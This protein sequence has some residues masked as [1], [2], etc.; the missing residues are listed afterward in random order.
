[1]STP[2]LLPQSLVAAVEATHVPPLPQVLLRLLEAVEDDNVS[3]A[4]LAEL[5]SRDPVLT[6]RVLTAANSAAFRRGMAI[7]RIQDCVKVLGTRLVRA[8]ATCLAVQHTFDPMSRKLRANL[9]EFWRHSMMVAESARALAIASRA[10]RSEEAYLAGLLHDLG[11]LMLLAGLPEYAGILANCPDEATL[12]GLEQ[13][14]FGAD[15]AAVGAW[16]ADQWKLDSLLADAIL[17]HHRSEADIAMADP[18]SRLLW[19]AHSW[20][21]SRELPASTEALIGVAAADLAAPLEQARERVEK[22]ATALGLPEAPEGTDPARS[23]PVMP[24]DAAKADPP[25]TAESGIDATV[26]DLAMMQPMQRA[27]FALESDNE[28][29]YSLRESAR[30]LFGVN[31]LAFLRFDPA[32][33]TFSGAADGTQSALLRQLVIPLQPARSLVAVAAK[34]GKPSASID[35]KGGEPQSLADIQ[36]MRGLGAECLICVPM[37]TTRQ[38]VGVM[39]LGLTQA[40]FARIGKRINW[41]ISFARLAATSLD[42]WREAREQH[43]RSEADVAGRFERQAH[44]I[45]HE[46]G[47]PLGIIRNY[48]TLIERKLPESSPLHED[49]TI[50]GEEIERVSRIVEGMVEPAA[51][52]SDN[53]LNSVVREMISLYDHALFSP[54]GITVELALAPGPA[55][56]V[57]DRDAVKQILLNLCK[58][59]AE[60]MSQGG[61][62]TIATALDVFEGGRNHIELRIVDNGPGLPVEVQQRLRRGPVEQ[63]AGRR[64]IGLSVVSSLID[65]LGGKLFCKTTPGEG[66]A[67]WILIPT[68]TI[69]ALEETR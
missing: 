63:P 3:F 15:H 37:R 68:G 31:R 62:L 23:F 27:L 56:F 65:Q 22:I 55:R 10:P 46:A 30:I 25:E 29:L 61:Q 18:M 13:Q 44:R 33:A 1:M 47:N 42:A 21:V 54:R 9:T 12:P 57:G 17:F 36:L 34:S 20:I 40:Q 41:L 48:L 50:I 19:V 8:M 66:T 11:E 69:P 45:V 28:I 16:L 2:Q 5:I 53:D 14:A 7:V 59:A 52:A 51:D 43:T 4:F 39:A 58:N 60:A 67:F 64:G 35:S 38:L 32:T 49:L 26:R 24:A 6:S